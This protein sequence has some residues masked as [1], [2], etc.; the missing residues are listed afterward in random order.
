V[1]S[2]ELTRVTALVR[3]VTNR[4]LQNIIVNSAKGQVSVKTST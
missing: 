4:A 1:A 3:I 2:R